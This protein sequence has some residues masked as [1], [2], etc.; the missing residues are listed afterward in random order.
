MQGVGAISIINPEDTP[1]FARRLQLLMHEAQLRT[2]WQ[3][4]AKEYVKQFSYPIVVDQYEA[5]YKDSLK[6]YG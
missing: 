4:W 5:L 6:Q 3:D 2:I 1:E